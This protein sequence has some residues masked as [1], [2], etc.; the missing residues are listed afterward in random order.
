MENKKVKSVRENV[1]SYDGK[2]GKN[3]IHM[4]T[5]EEGVVIEGD[6]VLEGEYHSQKPTCE[7][8][9]AGQ[10]ATFE[11]E[12]RVNGQYTN[13]KFKP[14][15]AA[16]S[17]GF[18][19]GKKMEPKDQGTITALSCASTAANYYHQR[20]ATEEQVLAFAEKLFNWATSKSTLK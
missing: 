16:F 6:L 4:I 8:F 20:Q 11:T 12:K 3:Y 14:V 15:R 1:R 7:N 13:Y 2:N 19:G 5:L 9:V 10:E 18:K 17:N